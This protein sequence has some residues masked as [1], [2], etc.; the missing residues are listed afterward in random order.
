MGT[1][2]SDPEKLSRR[3]GDARKERLQFEDAE[4]ISLVINGPHGK[5]TENARL[6]GTVEELTQKIGA[7]CGVSAQFVPLLELYFSGYQLKPHTR[8]VRQCAEL[9]PVLLHE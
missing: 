1:C 2:V 5:H 4:T 7:T 6:S 8:T 3:V 9:C